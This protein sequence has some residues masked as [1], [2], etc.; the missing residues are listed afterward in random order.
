MFG[1][2]CTKYQLEPAP[3]PSVSISGVSGRP[4]AFAKAMASAT[5]W[6]IPAHMIWLVALA[7]WPAPFFAFDALRSFDLPQLLATSKAQG[8][9]V[10]PRDG[11]RGPLPEAAA[12]GLLPPRVRAVSALPACVP[13]LGR[14]KSGRPV[15]C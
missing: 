9:I 10:N 4:S 12:R 11:D 2:R 13:P 8:L 5:A 7:A 14:P 15:T 3:L 1:A 6:M